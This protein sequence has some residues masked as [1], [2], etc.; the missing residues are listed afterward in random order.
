MVS[1]KSMKYKKSIKINENLKLTMQQ[2]CILE[3]IKFFIKINL[4]TCDIIF[5]LLL[6]KTR[7]EDG[8]R[9]ED[10]RQKASPYS[11]FILPYP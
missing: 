4:Y 2:L 3:W 10:F 1:Q 8:Q 9:Y 7:Y 6:Q 5:M 11:S